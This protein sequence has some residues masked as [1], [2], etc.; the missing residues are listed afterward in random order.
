M[1]ILGGQALTEGD[2]IAGELVMSHGYATILASMS[3]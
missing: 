1:V 2:P 3:W